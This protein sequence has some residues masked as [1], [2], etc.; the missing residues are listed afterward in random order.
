MP[1]ADGFVIDGVT[2]S[3]DDLTFREQREMRKLIREEL[4]E[5]PDADID[6]M[7]LADVVPAFVY[8]VKKR[9]N[10]DLTLDDVLDMKLSD[11]IPDADGEAA[12]TPTGAAKKPAASG[13]RK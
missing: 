6:D 2:Y 1:E 10:P 4:A 7:A 11:F 5:N 13:R 12:E 8:V 9:D 3:P